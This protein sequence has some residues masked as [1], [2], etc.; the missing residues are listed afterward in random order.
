MNARE[1]RPVNIRRAVAQDHA[2]VVEFNM[3]MALESEG[4]RLDAQTLADGVAAMLSE[5]ANGFC[6]IAEVD[7]QPAGCLMVTY[8]WSDWRNGRFWWIQSVFVAPEFRRCGIYSRMHEF[9]RQAAK[10][11]GQSCGLRLYVEKNNSGAQATYAS[12][13][14]AP[15][16]Y[17]LFEEEFGAD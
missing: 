10:A 2:Q 5:P 13:G 9:V 17:D 6:L 7:G 16:H 4:R 3:A 8:E 1:S 14:M 11:D 15:T 12:L